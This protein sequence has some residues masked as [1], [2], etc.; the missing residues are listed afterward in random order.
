MLHI[1]SSEQFSHAEKQL[2]RQVSPRWLSLIG[3]TDI[4]PPTLYRILV[5]ECFCEKRQGPEIEALR[6][7]MRAIETCNPYRMT[8][9][10]D[11]LCEVT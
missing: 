11:K 8:P 9:E 2:I 6:R 7:V 1:D 5:V 3:R 4:N 10:F